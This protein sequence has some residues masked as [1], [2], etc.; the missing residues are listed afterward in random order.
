MSAAEIGQLLNDLALAWRALSAYPGGHPTATDAL[1]R[2]HATLERAFLVTGEIELGAVKDGL[3][4]GEQRFGGATA[5]RLAE[6]LRRRNAATVRLIP[7]ATSAEVETFLR[8]LIVDPRRAREA[9]SLSAELAA[10]G[11][12]GIQVRDLDFSSFHLVEADGKPTLPEAGGLWERMVKRLVASGQLP[13]ERLAAWI[14][15]GKSATELLAA[16][17][18]LPGSAPIE[19]SW[20]TAASAAAILAAVAEYAENPGADNARGIAFLWQMLEPRGQARLADALAGASLQRGDD[21]A[22]DGALISGLPAEIAEAVRRA[23]AARIAL[24]GRE[25]AG[26]PLDSGSIERMRRLFV[27]QDLDEPLP[28]AGDQ[29]IELLLELPRGASRVDLPAGAAALLPELA[30]A[31]VGRAAG[32]ARAELAERPDL[33]PEGLPWILD[34]LTT[35]YRRLLAAGRLR[36][37]VDLVE[38]IR[39][40]AVAG[41]AD[42]SAAA[43]AEYR[44]ALG[45]MADAESIGALVAGLH[46]LPA[47]ALEPL[48][49]LLELLGSGAVRHLLTALAVE[50]DRNTRHRLLDLLAALGPVV[51]RDAAALLADPRWF[52][53][54]NMLVLL[55]RVGDPG[56]LP[57]IRRCAA[58]ADLRVRLE[59][60]RNLFAFEAEVP[61]ELLRGAIHHSDSRLAEDAIELA[62]SRGIAEAVEP[63]VELLAAWDPFRKRRGARLKALRALGDLAEPRALDGLERFAGRFGWPP[64][65]AEERRAYFRALGSYPIE[66]RRPWVEKGLRSRDAEVRRLARELASSEGAR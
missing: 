53:V 63:L 40:R 37:C 24:A 19:G 38:R 49:M 36:Q 25:A 46:Q 1:D 32:V 54:R 34:R 39:N 55:R 52:V 22:S 64:V 18:G 41:G 66:A 58:H 50:E 6:L 33:P 56:S 8:A 59:A 4:H 48:R 21:L 17:V 42:G 47:D 35:S 65:A 9:G 14:A 30:E 15:G 57:E 5:L 51:A 12:V 60:I 3:L 27:G 2:A 31:A 7:G 61:R 11:L 23:R 62:G 10:A 28:E 29:A 44:A 20:R 43:A 13:P 26:A 16:L 45:R